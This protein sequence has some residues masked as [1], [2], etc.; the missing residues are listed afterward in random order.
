MAIRVY[1][2]TASAGPTEEEAAAILG[3]SPIGKKT[4][5]QPAPRTN[6]V[7]EP[8]SELLEL[9]RRVVDGEDV[10]LEM[11]RLATVENQSLDRYIQSI[12]STRWNTGVVGELLNNGRSFPYDSIPVEARSDEMAIFYL[13]NL[14]R[15]DLVL[16]PYAERTDAVCRA[17]MQISCVDDISTLPV[18][19]QT[20]E[21]FLS[22]TNVVGFYRLY[23]ELDRVFG[24]GF[25]LRVASVAPR[26]LSSAG[27][28]TIMHE[29]D[30]PHRGAVSSPVV[31][32][33]LRSGCASLDCLFPFRQTH[34]RVMAALG[35]CSDAIYKDRTDEVIASALDT[36][37]GTRPWKNLPEVRA[38]LKMHPDPNPT[39][40]LAHWRARQDEYTARTGHLVRDTIYGI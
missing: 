25:W 12:P 31:N 16:I 19:F 4:I 3:L 39:G 36:G 24:D 18:E 2:T 11:I 35:F 37:F 21:W 6:A 33:L 10:V 17:S 30:R 20:Q 22:L 32:L 38:Y 8:S 14:R 7:L 1:G 5:T 9:Q 23:D 34:E 29:I 28:T 27:G 13:R 15:K 40:G 26:I